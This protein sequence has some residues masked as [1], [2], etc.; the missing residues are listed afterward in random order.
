M[1][2]VVPVLLIIGIGMFFTL[3]M[4]FLAIYASARRVQ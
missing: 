4:T 3:S 2:E 1:T